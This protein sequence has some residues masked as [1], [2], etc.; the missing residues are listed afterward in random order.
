MLLTL[1]R[2]RSV[3]SDLPRTK[4]GFNVYHEEIWLT[5]LNCH[6][7]RSIMPVF[8]LWLV[9]EEFKPTSCGGVSKWAFKNMQ[10][11]TISIVNGLIENSSIEWFSTLVAHCRTRNGQIINYFL[12]FKAE[13]Q[14]FE[15]LEL[16]N[17]YHVKYQL[18][19]QL[20]IKYF[21]FLVTSIHI[22]IYTYSQ[23]YILNQQ[24]KTIINKL[25]SWMIWN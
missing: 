16:F 18:K 22:N 6:V 12:V 4:R 25:K 8:R 15:F 11:S 5:S 7:T 1:L 3:R 14:L 10:S 13:Y 9:S 2:T 21:V 20:I 17:Y 23:K 19:F 24:Q